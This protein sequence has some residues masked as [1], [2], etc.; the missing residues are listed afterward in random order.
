MG[1]I[2]FRLTPL[3]YF[4]T[5]MKGDTLFGQLCWTIRNH[6]GEK[7]LSELLAGYTEGKPAFIVSDALPAGFMP[8]PAAPARVFGFARNDP[9]NRKQTKRLRWQ[10]VD[11]LN[12]PVAQWSQTLTTGE[13]DFSR[14]QVR[15]HNSLNRLTL[16]T[17]KGAGFSPF[18]RTETWYR[19]GETLDV[20]LWSDGRLNADTLYSLLILIGETGFGKEAST[21]AGRFNVAPGEHLSFE[22]TGYRHFL[23]LGPCAPQG[24]AW[25]SAECY[26][27]TF[28]RFGRHGDQ[29]V[30][31][32]KPFKNPVLLA[33][34]GALLCPVKPPAK[35]WLGQG[36]IG[37]SP[38]LPETVHQGYSIALGVTL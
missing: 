6:L 2:R 1:L 34:T 22:P 23:T 10:P 32:G 28:V 30:H 36:L 17:G 31:C 29:A 37:V 3:S 18:D 26:Y 4:H 38:A 8:R 13:A 5:P 27:N 7:T 9:Q 20:Y 16:T 14:T 19:P 25:H 12:R 33:D 21:G 15:T 24:L 35:P 11:Q